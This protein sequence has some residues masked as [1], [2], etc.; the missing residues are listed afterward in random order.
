MKIKKVY[1]LCYLKLPKNWIFLLIKNKLLIL[2]I[3]NK[4]LKFYF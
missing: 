2:L 4:L 1:I 3:K